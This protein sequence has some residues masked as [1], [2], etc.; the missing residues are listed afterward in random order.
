MRMTAGPKLLLQ[1]GDRVVALAAFSNLDT[2]ARI[3]AL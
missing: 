3:L 2:E 1:R